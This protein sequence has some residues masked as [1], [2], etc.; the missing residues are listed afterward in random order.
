MVDEMVSGQRVDE[1]AVA[2]PVGGGDG[3]ELAVAR[4][5]GHATGPSHEVVAVVGEEGGGHED[6]RIVAGRAA[7]T[8]VAI[9]AASPT[10]S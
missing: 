4:R 8:I 3:D 5:R 9:A 7:S 6:Q 1:V 10:A 2:V